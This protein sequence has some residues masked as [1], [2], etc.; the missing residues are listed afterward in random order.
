MSNFRLRRGLGVG[1]SLGKQRFYLECSV[2]C[3]LR[4]FDGSNLG[5]GDDF[6]INRTRSSLCCNL[7][8]IAVVL[9]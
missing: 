4:R 1:F 9:R 8:V 5:G 7:I 6:V 2:L 3:H